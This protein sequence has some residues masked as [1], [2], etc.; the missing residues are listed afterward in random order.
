MYEKRTS[1]SEKLM[2]APSDGVAPSS[3]NA[4]HDRPTLS[5]P[6]RAARA[7]GREGANS[8]KAQQA[9]SVRTNRLS[10]YR[11]Q[12]AVTRPAFR[13][14]LRELGKQARAR[15]LRSSAAP[16]IQGF[17]LPADTR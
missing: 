5:R 1:G 17:R 15:D 9:G 13:A 11:A 14:A 10:E 12:A 7:T 2:L 6:A 4:T 3:S 8:D 16:S